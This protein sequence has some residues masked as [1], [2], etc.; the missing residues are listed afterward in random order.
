MKQ[1]IFDRI[2]KIQRISFVL[3][4]FF[5]SICMIVF[6]ILG[7]KATRISLG[8]LFLLA[9]V[10]HILEV[11]RCRHNIPAMVIYIFLSIVGVTLGLISIFMESIDLATVCLIFGIMDVSSGALEITTNAAIFK[12]SI[13][14]PTN[15]T[16]YAISTADII[17]GIILIIKLEEGLL[18]HVLYLALVFIVNGIVALIESI[19]DFKLNE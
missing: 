8:I 13:K 12:K 11:H 3:Y 6:S 15:F 16:E 17:F 5:C 10:F 18:V 14:S 4:C 7:Y 2:E 19:K 1:E 9:S